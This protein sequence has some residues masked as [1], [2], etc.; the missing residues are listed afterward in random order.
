MYQ[1]LNHIKIK[2]QIKYMCSHIGVSH[3]E[4]EEKNIQ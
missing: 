2:L 1:G 4:S 3:E